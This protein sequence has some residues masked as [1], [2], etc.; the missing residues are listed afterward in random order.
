MKEK[1]IK[2]FATQIP[3]IG[4]E[5]EE[6]TV[7]VEFDVEELLDEIENSDIYDYAVDNLNLVNENEVKSIEDFDED[8]LVEALEDLNYNFSIRIDKDLCVEYLENL[9]YFVTDERDISNGYDYVDNC[10]FEDI[11]N[12]FDSLDLFSR[13]KMRDL[14]I[15]ILI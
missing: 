15:N 10:L 4:E 11:V 12:K 8:E 1:T 2:L 3:Y 13:Q 6:N 9:G 14:I 5:L 7:Y